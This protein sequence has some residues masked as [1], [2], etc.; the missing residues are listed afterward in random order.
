MSGI[1][2]V[3]YERRAPAF[4]ALPLSIAIPTYC[5]EQVLV[6][7]IESLLALDVRAAEILVLD[8]TADHE[9]QTE[10]MLRKWN[11]EGQVRWIRLPEPSIPGAMNKGML[12]ARQDIVLFLDD[13]I[14][15]LDRLVAEHM[16]AHRA[17]HRLVAGRV[18]QPW[19]DD[20]L[21][22]PWSAKQFASTES[23]EIDGFMG[24][25]FSLRRSEALELGGFD[26]NFV[27]VA[28][29]FEREFADRWRA[30]GGKIHFCPDAAIRHLKAASGG[31]RIFG[32]HLT[33]LF[34]AHSVGAYYYLLR[35][36]GAESRV[37]VFLARPF[38]SIM[39]RHHLRRPWWI[40]VTLLAELTGM[41]WALMLRARGP[42]YCR[43]RA[44]E[45]G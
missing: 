38:R 41:L 40:P 24:G 21:N 32:E 34:P 27:R 10:A 39:T 17:G 13:D 43:A 35:S 28:Y 31:T 29:H 45:R 30:R 8:Q 3:T 44:G 16:N 18:L 5:R 22:V 26:E 25:N 7:T 37:R 15:P 1:G 33:T 20:F 6:E 2:S 12:D 23:R 11:E 19:D 42:R 4:G 36:Q 9:P 14:V